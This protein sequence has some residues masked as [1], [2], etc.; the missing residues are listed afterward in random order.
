MTGLAIAGATVVAVILVM[1][2]EAA[3]AAHNERALRAKGAI[4][5]A[6]DVYPLMRWAYP[7]SFVA[8]AVEG[9]VTGPSPPDVLASGLAL[10]GLSKAL[11]IWAISTLGLRWTFRVLVLPDAPL[12]A[13]G[14]YALVRHPNYVAVVGEIVG[15][16][17]IV[18]APVTGP[19][20]VLGFGTLLLRRIAV[21]DR[22]LGRQ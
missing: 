13:H 4:E 2:G 19:L 22:A 17:L 15:V 5:P 12:V 6:G 14:P 8:M 20:A 7:A 9:A 16:A 18:W 1:A 11:K 3:L 21:E 10:F